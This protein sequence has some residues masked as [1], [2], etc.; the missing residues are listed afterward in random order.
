M[1][2]SNEF[3]SI[4][5]AE[6]RSSQKD[7]WVSSESQNANRDATQPPTTLVHSL[8]HHDIITMPLRVCICVYVCMF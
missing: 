6:F 1:M 5:E 2:D 3:A 8:T 7:D 4:V